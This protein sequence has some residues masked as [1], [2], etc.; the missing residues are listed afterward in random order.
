MEGNQRGKRGRSNL[1][2]TLVKKTKSSKPLKFDIIDL[3][4]E[5]FIANKKVFNCG[6]VDYNGVTYMFYRYEI[7]HGD[8]NTEIGMCE[9][10]TDYYPK[11]NTNRRLDI[12]R[13]CSK[14]T[15]F[16]DPRP[17]VYKKDLYFMFAHGMVVPFNDYNGWCCSL[18]I[19]R[20]KD[21]K[22]SIPVIPNYGENI[23]ASNKG[24]T[25]HY[26]Q[27][28]NWMPL[29]QKDRLYFVYM[30]NPYTLIECDPDTGQ[31]RE[32]HKS[33]EYK[34]DFWKHGSFIGGGTPFVEYKGK[35]YSF[36]H[37]FTLQDPKVNTT[38][39]YHVGLM[40]LDENL[41]FCEMSKEPIMS[42]EW[43]IAQDLRP[44]NNWW[45][46]NV[47]FPCG[48]VLRKINGVDHFAMSY[49]WQDCRCKIAMIPVEGAIKGMT[50][51][52]I[53]T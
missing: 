32:V 5:M 31:C 39:Q 42:G 17:F 6:I 52:K 2:K 44:Q 15:T 13:H 43:N 4:N 20:L 28:K 23:N 1:M 26:S 38:R 49:G 27:E 45:R 24:R 37:S 8:Y 21:Q 11:E 30:V 10:G 25:T 41:K 18:G 7:P 34:T 46:P 51:V 48:L 50:K 35:F 33:L 3:P 12:I 40:S 29:I 14:I 47:V 22:I 19:C 36:F 16:D 9:L 53:K